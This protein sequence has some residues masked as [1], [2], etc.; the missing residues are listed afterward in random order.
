M[1]PYIVIVFVLFCIVNYKKLGHFFW[2]TITSIKEWIKRQY[3]LA[4]IN[5]KSE[6]R[7]IKF[8]IKSD[9][10][11]KDINDSKKGILGYLILIKNQYVSAFIILMVFLIVIFINYNSKGFSF[12]DTV[13]HLWNLLQK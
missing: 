3:R 9:K 1:L 11:K 13:D 12:S 6:I 10:F 4:R 7:R 2:G 8:Y 5:I